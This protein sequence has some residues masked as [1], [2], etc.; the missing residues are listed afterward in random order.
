MIKQAQILDEIAQD[1]IRNVDLLPRITDGL[2]K[3][4]KHLPRWKFA[5][6]I[7]MTIITLVIILF[8]IPE[9]ANAMR[10]LFGYMPGTG[11]VENNGAIRVL[12]EPVSLTRE[13][14]TLTVEQ[15]VMDGQQTLVVYRVEGIPQEAYPKSESGISCAGVPALRLPDGTQLEFVNGEGSGLVDGYR[16]G[17]IFPPVPAGVE[18]GT[19]VLPCLSGVKPGAAPENWELPL[20][21]VPLPPDVTVIPL[22]EVNPPAVKTAQPAPDVSVAVSDTFFGI[23]FHLES[24]ERIG[25][26]YR[27]VTSIRWEEGI[28]PDEGVGT[29]AQINLVDADGKKINLV[30]AYEDLSDDPTRTVMVF[31][32]D[33][34]EFKN[35]LTLS[36]P[37]VMANLNP[38]DQ[39]SF[40]F[41]PGRDFTAGQS[42]LVNQEIEVLG[43]PVKILSARYVRHEDVQGENWLRSIPEDMFGIEFTIEAGEEFFNLPLL[44]KS[45]YGS[46]GASTFGGSERDETGL[47]HSYAMMSGTI[48][49]SLTI[50]VPYVS[51]N[52]TWTITWTPDLSSMASGAEENSILEATPIVEK[53]VPLED[54]FYLIGRMDWS[55]PAVSSVEGDAA[56]ILV[57]DANGRQIPLEAVSSEV[58]G[59]LGVDPGLWIVKANDTPLVSP[60]KLQVNQVNVNLSQP[61][62]F[63]FDPGENPQPGEEFVINYPLDIFG[64]PIEIKTAKFLQEQQM[65]GYEFTIQAD[66]CVRQ[67]WLSLEGSSGQSFGGESSSTE[68]NEA[69]EITARALVTD[70]NFNQPVLIG[71]RSAVLLGLWETT[72][73]INP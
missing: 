16:D 66:A 67:L 70:N 72:F 40:E 57:E 32:M 3:E 44:V 11:V 12:A 56:N 24:M 29:G 27:L 8:S 63:T 46:G 55:N 37:W 41:V 53:I 18:S 14:V 35:P 73:S 7:G 34:I 58:F 17:F 23:Q 33:N 10:R 47:I 39:T 1:K 54:G 6:V 28:Y 65:S 61:Y 21:F 71:I 36:L 26:G 5:T 62:T 15:V 20:Y 60:L 31:S 50:S 64:C 19:F 68:R 49:G 4:N 25:D 43:Q 22:V 9:V 59:I 51:I 42:R 48:E 69:G 52:H 13:G 38:E 30:P 2:K 45:G